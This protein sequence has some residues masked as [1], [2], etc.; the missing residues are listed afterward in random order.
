MYQ[1]DTELSLHDLLC[2][3]D[4]DVYYNMGQEETHLK[5]IV[6]WAED[7]V[8]SG[9]SSPALLILA[10]LNLDAM[11]DK[12]EVNLYLQR[13][14]CEQNIRW[15][16]IRV[17]TLVWLKYQLMHLLQCRSVDEI[18]ATLYSF[19]TAC[20]DQSPLFF[21]RTARRLSYLYYELFDD[22]G[23]DYSFA[24]SSMTSDAIINF[25]STRILPYYQAV[26]K[27]QWLLW[28]AETR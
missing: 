4:F 19:S 25:V 17:S 9:D 12:H 11:P 5:S 10:S 6:Q 24:A 20:F 23:P 16:A 18:E 13:Y 14:L 2:L 28:L 3:K 27:P 15:P 1:P 22:W 8:V 7:N 21:T 26:N